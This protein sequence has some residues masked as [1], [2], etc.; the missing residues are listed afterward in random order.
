MVC[1]VW[2]FELAKV[3]VLQMKSLGSGKKMALVSKKNVVV[4]RRIPSHHSPGS[5]VSNRVSKLIGVQL[6]IAQLPMWTFILSKQER[7]FCED[8]ALV[9][10]G[11]PHIFF[12]VS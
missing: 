8:I 1:Y 6:S 10:G 5:K 2:F 9:S 11:L 3:K 12:L 7:I 4:F